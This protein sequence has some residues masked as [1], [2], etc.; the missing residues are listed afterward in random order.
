[1]LTDELKYTIAELLEDC[2]EDWCLFATEVLGV[3]L[4]DQ[5][6]EILRSVQFNK[7]TSVKSGTA[8]G[9]DFVAAVAAL[10]FLYLT[11]GFDEEGKLV[12][13]TKVALTAP[14]DRQIGNIMMP[15][16]SRIYHRMVANGFGFLSGR[17]QA[18]GIKTDYEEWFLTGFKADEHNHEAWSG[19]HAV[20]TCFIVTEASGIDETI[21]NA[22]EGNLQGNSRLLIVFN[23]NNGTGYAAASQKKPGWAKFRLDSL[24]APNVLEKRIVI[25]GQVDWNWVNDKVY[26]WCTVINPA[27]FLE[28]EGDFWWENEKGKLCYRPNDLFRVK[29]RGMAPK[30]SHGALVPLEWIEAANRR[31][32]L[33][34]E[35]KWKITKPLR[36]GV[37][38]AGMGR[39]SS[40]FCPRY[41]NYVPAFEMVHSG[42]TANHMEIVGK[43]KNILAANTDKFAGLYP[44]AYID[45]IGEGA[46]VYSRLI[47]L[48][49]ERVHSVKFSEGADWNG[50][51]LK[52]RTGQY[53][54]LN[55]R[56]YLFWCV[57]EWLDPICNTGAA[58]PEDDELTQEL[59]EIQWKFRSDGSIQIEPKEEIIKRIGRSPD[60]SDSLANTFYPVADFDINAQKKKQDNT[61]YFF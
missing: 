49:L 58:L 32:R 47:E 29:V 59:T 40:G 45:T 5:Q 13:N 24:N 19:F 1:M 18:Y 39:D 50:D 60:K 55:M 14:T 25:P 15:E 46:G 43:T 44:S 12:D 6:K 56:A 22:I 36:L 26:E 27:D 28:A 37:D 30:V 57:R 7:K 41:G 23:D 21:F 34:Q 31:W 11:P 48:G 16:V 9:K 2:K 53:E 3:Y 61:Q 8:R 54:F 4:D 20:N 17:L 35:Q 51:K 52:D 33:Q 42:G 10:C 38:V